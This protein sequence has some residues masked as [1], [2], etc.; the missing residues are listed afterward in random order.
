MGVGGQLEKMQVTAYKDGSFRTALGKPFTVMINPSSYRRSYR[1]VYNDVK[2]QGS[3]GGSPIFNRTLSDEVR[4][5]LWFD[6]TGVVPGKLPGLV[7][8]AQDGIA[9]AIDAFLKLVFDYNGDIHS[10]NLLILNWGTLVFQC[11]LTSLELNYTLFKP[12]G[13]PLRAKADCTFVEYQ[14]EAELAR[15][16]NRKSADL[17]HAVRVVAGDTLPLLCH[18]IYGDSRYYLQVAAFNGLDGF[19][20]LVP[21]TTLQFPPLSGDAA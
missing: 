16:A 7:P 14:T 6:G 2:G 13:T 18:R 12:D 11:R 10:P 1:I 20:A 19:R 21:G 8:Y 4:M 9:A 5:E 3:N 15:Q 17:T